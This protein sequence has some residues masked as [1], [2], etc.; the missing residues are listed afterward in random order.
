MRRPFEFLDYW[1]HHVSL[2]V[3]CRVH[4]FLHVIVNDS[5]LVQ[6]DN[7][8]N[9]KV[10]IS[11]YTKFEDK[12]MIE[13]TTQPPSLSSLFL[14]WGF[15]VPNVSCFLQFYAISYKVYIVCCKR[16]MLELAVL[17]TIVVSY[18]QVK[19]TEWKDKLFLM[20]FQILNKLGSFSCHKHTGI[21]ICI[22]PQIVVYRIC[23]FILLTR[24]R[25]Q[26]RS[27]LT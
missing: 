9:I 14:P 24:F 17:Q 3:H 8:K 10:I 22:L 16:Y 4:I 6:Y 18:L 15:R 25:W 12:C 11:K 23:V 2:W 27:I 5:L 19:D 1:G 13:L 26:T 7:L 20:T 21:I